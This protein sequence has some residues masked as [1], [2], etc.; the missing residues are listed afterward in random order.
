MSMAWCV[1]GQG[2]VCNTVTLVNYHR[3]LWVMQSRCWCMMYSG[4]CHLSVCVEADIA[5]VVPPLVGHEHRWTV[6]V[7]MASVVVRFDVPSKILTLGNTQIIF[8]ISLA[9]SYLCSYVIVLYG[10]QRDETQA[11]AAFRGREHWHTSEGD[12]W[13]IGFTWRWRLSLCRSYQL[14]IS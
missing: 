8:G 2:V 11:P 14:C 12:F 10:I 13:H 5:M 1:A 6:I 9:F 4:L 7:E 3:S